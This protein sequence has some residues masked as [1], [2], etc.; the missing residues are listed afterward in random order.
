[1]CTQC[2]P[3]CADDGMSGSNGNH[4]LVS[5]SAALSSSDIWHAATVSVTQQLFGPF[6]ARADLRWALHVPGGFSPARTRLVPNTV[7]LSL[8]SSHSL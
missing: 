6:R 7:K 4:R 1:M 3:R 8:S 2:C 5:P